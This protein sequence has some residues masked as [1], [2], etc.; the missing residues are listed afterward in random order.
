[1]FLKIAKEQTNDYKENLKPLIYQGNNIIEFCS[2]PILDNSMRISK[3]KTQELK[4]IISTI[5]KTTKSLEEILKLY[6]K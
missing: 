5:Q 2:T 6:E 3:Y 4:K 1:M